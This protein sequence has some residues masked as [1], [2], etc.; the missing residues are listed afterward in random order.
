[1]RK[2]L[3]ESVKPFQRSCDYTLLSNFDDIIFRAH[4]KILSCHDIIFSTKKL[5]VLKYHLGGMFTERS[6]IAGLQA[7]HMID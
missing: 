5:R 1:M 3:H 7:L 2:Q 4:D 6:L